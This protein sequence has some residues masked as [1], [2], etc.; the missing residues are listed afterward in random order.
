[1]RNPSDLR[2]NYLEQSIARLKT[3]IESISEQIGWTLNDVDKNKLQRQIDRKFDQL[4]ETESEL[5]QLNQESLEQIDFDEVPF[6]NRDA[7]ISEITA[8][9]SPT[10]R[11]IT[12]P[13]GYGKTEFLKQIQKRLCSGCGA[14][15]EGE[16]ANPYRHQYVEIPPIKPIIIEHR[17]HQLKP[18]CGQRSHHSLRYEQITSSKGS[19]STNRYRSL[20]TTGKVIRPL[21]S[22]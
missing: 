12:A 14:P 5:S 8:T 22:S 3:E 13:K 15:L 2:K 21:V 19:S 10:Y 4:E 7:A 17:L 18:G 20:G 11:L 6:T 9:N 1:M 16:D